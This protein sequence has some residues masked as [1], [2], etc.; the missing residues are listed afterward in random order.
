MSRPEAGDSGQPKTA[1]IL[2][3]VQRGV[4]INK[5]KSGQN[6]KK[7]NGLI[8]GKVFFHI[9]CPSKSSLR[10]KNNDH[11]HCYETERRQGVQLL[12]GMRVQKVLM[13]FL[14]VKQLPSFDSFSLSLFIS[15]KPGLLC[16][17]FVPPPL[18]F[19]RR[20]FA[21]PYSR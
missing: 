21:Y 2:D 19:S 13:H 12:A 1:D 15:T 7:G 18:G 17:G 9:A 16:A 10:V 20:W 5:D 6:K 11:R 3:T 4:N 14:H 8:Q